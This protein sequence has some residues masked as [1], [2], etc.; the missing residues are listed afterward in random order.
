[1][2]TVPDVADLLRVSRATVYRLVDA[3]ALPVL[4]VGGQLR[5]LHKALQD[6][7]VEGALDAM[8]SGAKR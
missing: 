7:L 6:A 3:R 4:R 1:M 5:F 8:P 2:L